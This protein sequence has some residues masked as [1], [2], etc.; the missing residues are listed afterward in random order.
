[1]PPAVVSALFEV[2]GF[3]DLLEDAGVHAGLV[4][5]LLRLEPVLSLDLASGGR[6]P[7]LY[8]L[9]AHHSSEIRSLV[10][11]AHP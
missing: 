10:R 3:A 5:A 8:R 2:L 4:G 1:M 11:P 6:Y 7:G 9:L